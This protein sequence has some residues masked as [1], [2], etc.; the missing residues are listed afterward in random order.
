MSIQPLEIIANEGGSAVFA[1][2][3]LV[4]TSLPTAQIQRPGENMLTNIP[5]DDP[6][7]TFQDFMGDNRTYSYSGIQ[8]SDEGTLFSC[9][10]N[11]RE[12]DEPGV[13]TTV[14]C[15]WTL[16][17]QLHFCKHVHVVISCVN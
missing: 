7:L 12:A 2:S 16:V 5:S 4:S 14:N 3:P 8:R 11:S 6:R 9:I 15:K 10:V 1:C 17:P 13:L